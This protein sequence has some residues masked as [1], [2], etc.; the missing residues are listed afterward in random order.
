MEPTLLTP[1]AHE[2]EGAN[3]P[4][5]RLRR[6]LVTIAEAADNAPSAS[7]PQQAGSS[8][9]LEATYRFF[10]NE[11]VSAQ[12]VFQGHASATVERATAAAEVFVVH[13]TTEF[14]F[15]GEQPREGLGWISTK[16]EDGFML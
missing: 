11:N 12:C 15:G 9:A 7:L 6:R 14:R 13:D 3:L 5:K 4:D 16:R 10:G 1:I 2:F 8:A